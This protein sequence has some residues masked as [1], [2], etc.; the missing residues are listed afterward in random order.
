MNDPELKMTLFRAVIS[1]EET[2]KKKASYVD[3][4]C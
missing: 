2:K 3:V 4:G 1:G